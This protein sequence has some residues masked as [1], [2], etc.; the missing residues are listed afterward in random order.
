MIRFAPALTSLA[1]LL[2]L[3]ALP[4]CT[5]E[6]GGSSSSANTA[7][8]LSTQLPDG[9]V[10]DTWV[11]QVAKPEVL[12]TFLSNQ[13]WVSLV[14]KRDYR[15]AAKRLGGAGGTHAARA[16]ADASAMYRQAA[17][18]AAN[19]LI[20]TY[21]ET[22]QETDPIATAHLLAYAFAVNGDLDK[23][24]AE[25]AKMDGL[26][27]NPTAEWNA[28]L[29]AWI[30]GGAVWPPDLS[31]LPFSLPEPGSSAGEWPEAPSGPHYKLPER[32]DGTDSSEALV[33]V[34]DPLGLLALAVW[35]DTVA[36]GLAGDQAP[37]VELYNA[38]YRLPVEGPSKVRSDL[39]LEFI[40]GS[41][42]LSASDA[43]YLA[44]YFEA[45]SADLDAKYKD[46]SLLAHLVSQVRVDGAI[47]AE[48]VQDLSA[49]L[50]NRLV[51]DQA[52]AAG[53]T[54]D[55]AHR[56]FADI[57]RVGVLR[58]IALIAEL[59]GNRETSGILRIN[60]ME[61]SGESWTACPT[62]TLSLAAWDASNRYP[63]RP[64]ENLHNLIS[65]YPSLE[66]GR[67]S[68][69]VLALRVSRETPGGIPGN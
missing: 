27:A 21:S 32:V 19:S 56:T 5:G 43:A 55:G 37:A 33:G 30:E 29:K 53:G 17:L 16:H 58:N 1:L 68:L 38:R 28:P 3:S 20:E 39:P 64:T 54:T 2:S 52:E 4:G 57:A 65:R 49:A 14:T 25:L 63:L 35:H 69:E 51:A 22:P 31:A 62:S 61:L 50:R 42:Y 12:A 66:T 47:N 48:K 6:S 36:K 59:D 60:A 44:H 34:D 67:F 9:L 41:D 26:E 15:S 24:K 40:F 7:V 10:A 11:M 45:P 46:E 18:M 23:A 8:D 13:G